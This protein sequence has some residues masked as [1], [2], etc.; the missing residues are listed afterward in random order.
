M[1]QI[2]RC[3]D[4]TIRYVNAPQWQYVTEGHFISFLPPHPSLQCQGSAALKKIC[5]L[6]THN[7]KLPVFPSFLTFSLSGRPSSL[8]SISLSSSNCFVHGPFTF[9]FL[10]SASLANS[11][12]PSLS[13]TFLLGCTAVRHGSESYCTGPIRI[14]FEGASLQ[15]DGKQLLWSRNQAEAD[16]R[17][18]TGTELL[19]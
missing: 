14:Q 16:R 6:K 7:F 18:A 8:F 15:S 11:L 3:T 10:I 17:E 1:V 4:C 2:V 13:I 5:A 9:L 19:H 12:T